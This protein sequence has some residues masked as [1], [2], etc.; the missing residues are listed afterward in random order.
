MKRLL[1]EGGGAF[2]LAAVFPAVIPLAAVP[3]FTD[4]TEQAGLDIS[5]GELPPDLPLNG[6]TPDFYVS[7]V[8][9]VDVD[10]DGWPDIHLTRFNAPGALY[11]NN[12]DGT[13]TDILPGSGLE[14][15]R[16]ANSAAWGD[17][18]NDGDPDVFLSSLLEDRHYYFVNIGDGTFR[19]AALEHG[20]ALPVE[21]LHHGMSVATGDV[22]RDGWLDLFI[23]EWGVDLEG[24]DPTDHT[25][26]MVNRGPE[27]PGHFRNASREAGLVIEGTRL[28]NEQHGFSAFLSDFDGDGWLDL[29]YIADF[30]NSEF[31]WGRGNGRFTEATESARV[32]TEQ[33]GMGGAVGDIDNDG[34]LDWFVTS[35]DGTFSD[36]LDGNRLYRYD[37]GR[38]FT[39]VTDE[40]GVRNGG[41]AW[42]AAF[43]D[44]DN[45]GDLD[46]VQTNGFMPGEPGPPDDPFTERSLLWINDGE[47]RFTE[48]GA[49]AGI[50]DTARGQGIAVL[51]FDRDGDLD[52]I[53]TNSYYKPVLYRNDTPLTGT[54]LQVDLRGTVSNRDAVGT[55]IE[56][57]TEPGGAVQMR[58][59]TPANGYFAQSEGTVH[60]GFGEF[61]GP[62]HRLTVS[63]PAGGTLE[64]S[65]L[66]LNRKITLTE[67]DED[68]QR[69]PEIISAPAG[70][71]AERDQRVV[72]AVEVLA[73]PE[74]SYQW[75]R[76]GVVLEGETG[77]QLVVEAMRPFD[78]GLYSVKVANALG[79]AQTDPVRLDYRPPANGH[80]VA[81][82]WNELN[83][84]AIRVDYPDPTVHSRNL[85]HCSVAMWDAYVAYDR[86]GKRVPYLQ[87]ETG[88]GEDLEA[89]R[90]EAISYAAYRVLSSRYQL[91]PSR[92]YSQADFDAKM[93][94]LGYD[95]ENRT[96]TG[97]SPAAIGNR[98]AAKV[99]AYGW[100]DGANEAHGYADVTGYEPV[101]EPLIFKLPGV[102]VVDPN[103][104]QPLSFDFLV[105]QNGLPVGAATQDFLGLNWRQVQPFAL[106][107]PADG[108]PPLDPGPPPQLGGTGDAA[109]KEGAL[110]VIRYSSVLDPETA[111]TIDVSPG[112]YYNNTLGTNDGSGYAENP[113]TG[114]PYAPNRVNLA[115][116][117][118][119]IAEFWADGPDSE[120]PPGHWN[121]LANHVTETIPEKRLYGDG[122]LLDDLAWDVHLYF[123]LNGALHD[124]AIAA[125]AAKRYHDY[126]RPVTLIRYMGGLGQSSDPEGPSYHP[127]GLPLEPGLVEV[128]TE[129]SAAPG[130]PHEDL[131]EH[132]GE[133]AL[134]CWQGEPEDPETEVGG[135]GWITA[136]RWMPYQQ[137][138]FVTPPF[139]A[140][141]S[142]HSAFS[143]AAAEVL[144][145]FTGSPYFPGGAHHYDFDQGNFLH[146]ERGPS[147]TV[148]LTWARYYDAADEAGLSRLY[149]GI[150]VPADDFAGRITGSR[151]GIGAWEKARGYFEGTAAPPAWRI[152]TREQ[153]FLLENPE[154]GRMRGEM[155]AAGRP[156][157][158]MRL[159]SG[160]PRNRIQVHLSS[161]L[162]DWKTVPFSEV[163]QSLE[164]TDHGNAEAVLSPENGESR[165]MRLFLPSAESGEGVPGGEK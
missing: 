83:L 30:G 55:R 122:S 115:D 26:L 141:V 9:V 18:D 37:G 112:A 49:S 155:D 164:F 110:T 86:S 101:N 142:G 66:E 127:E 13:F 17:F 123:A 95:P 140:Y 156:L 63:W 79:E 39:D 136:S 10:G 38:R 128:I 70:G 77:P 90:R 116:Y 108:R 137:F 160:L 4:V 84:D 82:Q 93:E 132:I 64:L 109:F 20:L 73:N 158:R 153:R 41:W 118:R 99:L 124:A 134:W 94:E 34:D 163:L 16:R 138:S 24:A 14:V 12:R 19:E 69:P 111:G 106:E 162:Q 42:G 97:R 165:F 48:V 102:E 151:A 125:W 21:G 67:V 50:A 59:L 135:V 56:A 133:I 11:R 80:S 107:L 126:V 1:P 149:G 85:F 68:L 60:F 105:L 119:I 100:R 152:E 46:L 146:F 131:R 22:N 88:T 143:R 103:R 121:T 61:E 58:E 51:D 23:T 8:A 154:A 54:W 98:I 62:L 65:G 89:A 76:N 117:A 92:A 81:R 114:E 161:D 144:S 87:E 96:M 74:P 32:G 44:A 104:W 52:F 25:A 78:A 91:S 31:F 6:S 120:T 27:A 47:G 40:A 71:E 72:L 29:G 45:D 3:V 15:A 157:L 36:G 33:N 147:E 2:V 148:R 53:V 43:F 113:I 145:A 75:L 28:P 130:G 7:S 35:I 5:H 129:A 159:P 57:E 139:A 150:H